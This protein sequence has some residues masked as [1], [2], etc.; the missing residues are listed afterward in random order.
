[1][2]LLFAFIATTT[3]NLT[4]YLPGLINSFG[5]IFKL[6]WN[7][8][9]I[10]ITIAAFFIAPWY[11]K[12]SIEVAYQLLNITWYYSMF[13][14]PIV[15]IMITDYWILRKRKLNVKELYKEESKKYSNGINWKGIIAFIMG[16]GIEY[17]LALLQ[18]KLFYVYFIPLPGF[19]LV[20][21]YG[22][23]TSSISYYL[24]SKLFRKK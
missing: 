9:I 13:L 11:V 19:E 14:G 21:Y 6:N 18:G 10:I 5:R 22:L 12:N 15:G 3:T 24:L 4:G 1:L 17:I 2:G 7:K 16:I 20:W 23:I 8:A